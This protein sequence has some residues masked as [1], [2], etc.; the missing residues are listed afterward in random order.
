MKQIVIKTV[1]L[2]TIGCASFLTACTQ[3]S[4]TTAKLT[5]Q[6]LNTTSIGGTATEESLLGLN[7]EITD[8]PLV[9]TV[10]LG[11]NLRQNMELKQVQGTD[12][13]V[14]LEM[15]NQNNVVIIFNNVINQSRQTLVGGD[16]DQAV[17]VNVSIDENGGN[18][19]SLKFQDE[20][21]LEIIKNIDVDGNVSYSKMGSTASV[22]CSDFATLE[23]ILTKI[24]TN[25]MID[26]NTQGP[27]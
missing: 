15:G 26:P 8:P 24:N 7:C 21:I 10:M 17:N 20:S 6:E 12:E 1:T 14:G 5:A 3:E 23:D 19:Y 16:T 18:K 2:V 27:Q 9:Q 4:A 11:L 25:P 13:V 22:N